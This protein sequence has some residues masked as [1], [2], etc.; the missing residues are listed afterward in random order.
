MASSRGTSTQSIRTTLD[1]L[2]QSVD[3]TLS[4]ASLR[5]EARN[6]LLANDG[7][8]REAGFS[9]SLPGAKAK[10]SKWAQVD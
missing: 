9:R 8:R 1:R 4:Y 5:S 6:L 10:G 3:K 7:F 2:L